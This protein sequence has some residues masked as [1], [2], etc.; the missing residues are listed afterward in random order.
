M[1]Y[2]IYNEASLDIYKIAENESDLSALN[3]PSVSYLTVPASQE[4]FNAV[5]LNLKNILTYNGTSN[6]LVDLPIL[7][8]KEQ[9]IQYI[10]EYKSSITN[11]LNNNPQSNVFSRW[12]NY[13]NYLNSLNIDLIFPPPKTTT[14]QT[15]EQYIQSTGNPFYSILQLP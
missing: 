9:T 3:L 14:T 8:N 7:L 12:N 15:L 1:P 4:D 11:F 2:F 6:R 13:L 5:K 10:N